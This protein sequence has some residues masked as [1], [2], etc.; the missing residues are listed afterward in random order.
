MKWTPGLAAAVLAV[1]LLGGRRLRDA[2]GFVGAFVAAVLVINAPFFVWA[3][4][5]VLAAYRQGSRAITNESIWY[6]VLRPMGLTK[7]GPE[8]Q[9]SGAPHSA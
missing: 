2:V 1:W 9:S 8:W 5:N 3:Q 6:F 7:P 4:H